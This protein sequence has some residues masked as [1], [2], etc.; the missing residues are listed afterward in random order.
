MGVAVGLIAGL[1]ASASSASA[2]VGAPAA[3]VQAIAADAQFLEYAPPPASPGV[4]CLID[5]GVDPNPDTT[6]ILAGSY[7][8]QPGTDTA[9]ELSKLNPRID[10]GGHP[11]GHGTY[12]A[13]IMA[14]PVNGW[15][16]VGI[17]PTSVRVYNVKALASGRGTFTFAVYANSI[18]HCAAGPVGV[19]GIKVVNLSIASGTQPTSADVD[20]IQSAAVDARRVGISVVGAAGNDGAGLSYPAAATG[21]F[22]VGASDANPASLGVFCAASGRGPDLKLLA[23]G[24]GTQSELSGGGNGIDVSFSDDGTPAWASGTSDASSIVSAVLASMRAYAPGL[25]ANQA[26]DCLTTTAVDGGNLDAAAAFRACGLGT[27]VNEGLAAYETATAP[28]LQMASPPVMPAAAVPAAEP[29]AKSPGEHAGRAKSWLAR[30][31]VI[32]V[33]LRSSHLVIQLASVPPGA[34]VRV[35]VERKLPSGLFHVV[36]SRTGTRRVVRLKLIQWDR[37]AVLFLKNNRR[38]SAALITRHTAARVGMVS[39][40]TSDSRTRR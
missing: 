14:A 3:T 1:F 12:M 38:S 17:A 2:E 35:D 29:A 31:R 7:A 36:A 5:S 30:P 25:T 20:A 18:V 32:N 27:I 8:L 34:V 15:G 13:M 22:A 26:E 37:L 33:Q 10:P 39:G 4:V 24:C 6:P 11:D 19:S 16:M 40:L 9:D 23:P 21:V 28:A